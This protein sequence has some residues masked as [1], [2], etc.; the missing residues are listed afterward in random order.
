LLKPNRTGFLS[1]LCLILLA[2]FQLW[3][4][5]VAIGQWLS[6]FRFHSCCGTFW[7]LLEHG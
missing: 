1:L 6:N 4:N 3:A 7:R 5:L 2:S